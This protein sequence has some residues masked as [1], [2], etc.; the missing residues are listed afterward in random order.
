[1]T[2]WEGEEATIPHLRL[3]MVNYYCS[4]TKKFG[5]YEMLAN[6]SGT[7]TVWVVSGV[8]AGSPRYGLQ[9]TPFENDMF[10]RAVKLRRQQ[11]AC[12][13]FTCWTSSADL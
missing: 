4:L 7:G 13:R 12:A 3:T 11:E 10:I 2:T 8:S 5:Q 1:M 9:S 6:T